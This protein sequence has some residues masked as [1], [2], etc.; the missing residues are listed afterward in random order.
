MTEQ[1]KDQLTLWQEGILGAWYLRQDQLPIYELLLKQKNPFIECARRYGKTT[2]ILCYVIERLLTNPGFV[3][4]WCEPDKNQAREIVKPEMAKIFKTAPKELRPVW[5]ATDSF[6]WWPCTG[7]NQD[8]ASK[9]KLRGVNHDRGDSARGPF[10]NIIVADEF[11]TW[12]DPDY[13]VTEAL[14]PQL[15]TTNGPFIFASTPPEDLGHPYY[16]HKN[17]ALSDG[18]FIQRIIHDNKSLSP[19]RIQEIIAEC[20]GEHTPAFK[21]EYLCEPVADP[22]SLVIPEYSEAKH[23]VENDYPRPAHFDAYVGM[24]LGFN[25]FT[26][27]VFGYV[28]FTKRELVLE[29]EYVAAGKNSKEIVESCRSR[30]AGL[31]KDKKPYLRVS[32]NELQQL[33]DMTSLYGYTLNPTRKDDKLAAINELRLLFTEGR[34]KIKK[35]CVNLR[36]QLKVGIWNDRRTDFKRGEK[37]GHL[38]AVDALIYLSRSINWQHNPYP[39]LAGVTPINHHVSKEALDTMQANHDLQSVFGGGL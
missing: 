8:E 35:R 7:R 12:K 18:R 34:I 10:A 14:R 23:D 17:W 22:E 27:T 5:S 1:E 3:C 38:D 28:D 24:D 39:Q 36:Y 37:T 13:I 33:Y 6:Y 31:W 26:A 2:T 15:Q 16:D 19:E 11:G 21:R 30:E 32:D 25:D 20:R 4:M 9:L 29:D